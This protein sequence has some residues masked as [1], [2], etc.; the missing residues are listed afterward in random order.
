MGKGEG[1]GEGEGKGAGEADF[2]NGLFG[3]FSKCSILQSSC[4]NINNC[5]CGYFCMPCL[6]KQNAEKMGDSG[7]LHCV[8]GCCFPMI[9][10]FMQVR[11]PNC[12]IH[13]TSP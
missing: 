10:A 13:K 11:R 5:L 1:W 4:G 3:C 9:P 8:M 12:S 7:C 6:F 2:I